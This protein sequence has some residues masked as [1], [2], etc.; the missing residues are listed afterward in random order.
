MVKNKQ[1]TKNNQSFVCEHCGTEVPPHPNSSR[2][3]CNMCLWGKH[4]DINPGDRLHRCKGLLK[5]VSL[6]IANRKEQ[7]EY[8]CQSCG[9]SVRCKVAPDDEREVVITLATTKS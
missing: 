2:D 3:H 9:A 5:P 1:F 6:Y 8:V 7:I 4:V